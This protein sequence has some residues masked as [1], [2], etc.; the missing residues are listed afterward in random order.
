MPRARPVHRLYQARCIRHNGQNRLTDSLIC[1]MHAD[2]EGDTM[3]GIEAHSMI[4]RS[5]TTSDRTTTLSRLDDVVSTAEEFDRAVSQALP[6]LLDRAA[7]Y[8][9]R[10]L[11]ET[12]QWSDD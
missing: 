8:T 9:K 7:G 4:T 10:F 2:F 3:I 6:L 5:R 11:R 1:P 12:G